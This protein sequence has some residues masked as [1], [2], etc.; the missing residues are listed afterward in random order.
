MKKKRYYLLTVITVFCLMLTF[1]FTGCGPGNRETGTKTEE[2]TKTDSNT[3]GEEET[4]DQTTD[5]ESDDTTSDDVDSEGSDSDDEDSDDSDDDDY[6]DP[7]DEEEGDQS[8]FFEKLDSLKQ[9]HET[10]SYTLSDITGDDVVDL[11][12]DCW[13]I[14]DG[15]SG[16]LYLAYEAI[17]NAHDLNKLLKTAGYGLEEVKFYKESGSL[18]LYSMGHGREDYSYYKLEDGEY[19]SVASKGR[20][21]EDENGSEGSWIY[22]SDEDEISES[23]FFEM[24]DGMEEG[25]A[26]L[27]DY[28]DWQD[29]EPNS[30]SMAD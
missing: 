18:V 15:G 17:D 19:T 25:G 10:V 7:D 8:V 4:K 5:Q 29:Y 30:Y 13:P 27:I 24:T 26:E 9:E 14:E 23:E 12:V 28:S 3:A 21:S 11:L 6:D 2:A 22:Y 16:H 1:G 20:M